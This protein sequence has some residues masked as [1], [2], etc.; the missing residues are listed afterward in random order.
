M[1]PRPYV[2][3]YSGEKGHQFLQEACIIASAKSFETF[4]MVSISDIPTIKYLKSW[5]VLWIK[6][7]RR[8]LNNAELVINISR[9][10][11]PLEVIYSQDT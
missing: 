2:G 1:S 3:S 5:E 7:K 8:F 11:Q 10:W 6:Q 9:H 4:I